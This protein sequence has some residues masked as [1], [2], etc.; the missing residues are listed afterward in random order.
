MARKINDE[1]AFAFYVSLGH[2]RSLEA[3][4][5]KY[6]VTRAAVTKAV[7]RGKWYERLAKIEAEAK[8][9]AD[10]KLAESRTQVLERHL[11]S[12]RAVQSK[13][14]Q[15]LQLHQFADATEGMR[16][17]VAG[18]KLE[19]VLMDQSSV[20]VGLSLPE[21][22]RRQIEMYVATDDEPE[23]LDHE[24]EDGDDLEP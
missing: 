12:V 22:T 13:A 2:E 14:L 7:R 20:N 23:D 16:A 10:K 11:R 19:R 6:N 5:Q 1:E 17:L 18:I 9:N 8:A 4:R 24:P 3:V 15:A 21:L